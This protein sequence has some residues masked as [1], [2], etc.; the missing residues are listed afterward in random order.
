[1][2]FSAVNITIAQ[3]DSILQQKY[4]LAEKNTPIYQVILKLTKE[5]GFDFSYNSNLI[6]DENK[7]SLS[8]NDWPLHRIIDTLFQ[9][10]S[11][12]Y[13]V[14]KNHIV[15][16]KKSDPPS[17]SNVLKK[18]RRP[19]TI[20][21]KVKEGKKNK[22]LP[23]ATISLKN[24][25]I[26]TISNDQGEFIF[27]IDPEFQSDTLIIS[28]IG[29]ENQ[30]I[31]VKKIENENIIFTLKEKRYSIQEVIVRTKDPNLI[32][33]KA[34]ERIEKN[35][36]T[37]KP[38]LLTSFYR[39][40]IKKEAQLTSVSEAL[41]KIYKP[42]NKFF[43]S[44]QVKVLKSRKTID[45]SKK[46]SLMLKLKAGLEAILFLDIVDERISFLNAHNRGLYSYSLEDISYFNQKDVYVISFK[47]A[48]ETAMPLY[49]GKLYVNLKNLAIIGAEFHLNKENIDKVSE[50][51]IIKKKWDIKVKPKTTSYFVSYKNSNGKY[52]LNHIRGDLT[53][54]IR[55]KGELFGDDFHVSFEMVSNNIKTQNINKFKSTETTKLHK[56]FIEQIGKYDPEF[57][58]DYNY[59]KANEPIQKT[60]KRL[61]SRIQMLEE[62]N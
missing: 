36:H 20:E 26:G 18:E 25:S 30:S 59:I 41:I 10:T 56:I 33:E 60:I 37:Q 50:S 32:L 43:Q 9:D 2:F 35:Y 8:A 19:I 6:N 17:T 29:Y 40:T 61:N 14:V 52:Y 46:D 38:I 11:L 51:L 22:P 58:G 13:N 62:A 44:S 45:Y 27:K 47:P 4:S 23:F 48:K 12:I 31:P 39:E 53:F 5:T 15:I 55:R 24:H 1:V 49:T 42:N 21:G 28:Y 7:I 3:N 16:H 54:K 34:V 57:W